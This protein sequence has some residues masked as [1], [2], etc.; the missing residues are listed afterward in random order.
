MNQN[1]LI[2]IVFSLG[3]VGIVWVICTM[4][5]ILGIKRGHLAGVMDG[6]E[7]TRKLITD[8]IKQGK[9]TL[10]GKPVRIVE[11]KPGSINDDPPLS[12]LI[13]P[14]P[15]KTDE[16]F[17]TDGNKFTCRRPDFVNLQESLCG[18]GDTME[19]AKADLLKHEFDKKRRELGE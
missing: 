15:F 12:P 16:V 9:V 19:E 14:V 1:L 4:Y 2:Q 10:D 8:A 18:F 7:Y 6:A 17:G 3:I 11:D 13:E 5:Y